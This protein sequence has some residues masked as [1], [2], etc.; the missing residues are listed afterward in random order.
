MN[1]QSAELTYRVGVY[2]TTRGNPRNRGA[3]RPIPYSHFFLR[4]ASLYAQRHIP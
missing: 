4:T 3:T 2:R 1:G